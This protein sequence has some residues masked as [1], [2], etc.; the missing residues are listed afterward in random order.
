MML[1]HQSLWFAEFLRQTI[2]QDL[3]RRQTREIQEEKNCQEHLNTIKINHD[4][5]VW[6]TCNTMEESLREQILSQWQWFEAK[7]TLKETFE[8]LNPHTNIYNSLVEE[9]TFLKDLQLN[10][11]VI[12][13][14][15][16]QC[17]T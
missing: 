2:F 17:A 16:E 4:N 10:Q 6:G 11:D 12:S 8:R 3:A 9:E 7:E 5:G 14:S 1:E 13:V 15:E